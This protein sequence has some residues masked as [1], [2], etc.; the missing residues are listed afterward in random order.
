MLTFFKNTSKPI[1]KHL[2]YAS[3]RFTHNAFFNYSI[4]KQIP[5]DFSV[6]DTNKAKIPVYTK[7]KLLSNWEI[8][9]KNSKIFSILTNFSDKKGDKNSKNEEPRPTID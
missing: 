3:K 9:N 5:R 7:S 6:L 2:K 1:N 8:P 4:S